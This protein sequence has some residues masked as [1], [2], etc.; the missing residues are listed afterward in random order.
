[1]RPTLTVSLPDAHA[2]LTDAIALVSTP[3][4]AARAPVSIRRLAWAIVASRH[5][6]QVTQRH[7]P[8]NSSGGPR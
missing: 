5:G 2:A 6:L 8:A 7:R 4:I 1:M 3:D